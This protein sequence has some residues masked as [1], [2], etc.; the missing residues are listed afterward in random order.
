MS[1]FGFCEYA[2][3]D[4]GGILFWYMLQLLSSGG[5]SYIDL[6]VGKFT[7]QSSPTTRSIHGQSQCLLEYWK[8]F[9]TVCDTL[10]KG[11]VIHIFTMQRFFSRFL[12]QALYWQCIPF[13]QLAETKPNDEHVVRI[14]LTGHKRIT[15]EV[16][17]E[18]PYKNFSPND[19]IRTLADLLVWSAGTTASAMIQC[20]KQSCRACS[21][22]WNTTKEY[23]SCSI[24]KMTYLH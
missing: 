9:V 8:M 18:E 3:E 10:P 23:D 16:S 13:I 5:K 22:N 11:V 6:E 7:Y 1:E 21:L 12:F 20:A 17:G 2:A 14:Q 15:L 4:V 24:I 19:Y